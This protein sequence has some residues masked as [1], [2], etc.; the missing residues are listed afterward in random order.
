MSN[1]FVVG[2]KYS[3]KDVYK[4]LD[5]PVEKQGGNW[6]TGYTKFED[7]FFI[8]ANINSAGRTGHDYNNKFIGD[9]FQWFSKNSHGIN[10]PTLKSILNPKGEIYIFTRDNSK[11]LMFTYH[12]L[13]E[14]KLIENSHP[15]RI[16]WSF[17]DHENRTTHPTEE[18]ELLE[19]YYEGTSKRRI[20]NTYER[21]PEARQ[22]C[23]DHYGLS[24]TV[25][26]FSFENKY[27][28]LGKEY[29]QVHHLVELN[30]I[31]KKYAVDPI[32]D[33]RPVC[34][35]CHAMLHRKK[36]AYSIEELKDVMLHLNS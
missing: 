34:P 21:N 4:I 24:C 13:G 8:F 7:D 1:L 20:V 9:Y 32:K 14:V 30:Q 35:N 6:N 33:L 18:N 15:V 2:N 26:N 12:G 11:E 27:G 16:L 10:S 25:C 22:K 19:E 23:I 3:R 29:I 5:V 36:P 28:V 17:K 31:G